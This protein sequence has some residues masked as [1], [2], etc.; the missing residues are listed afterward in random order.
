MTSRNLYSFEMSRGASG[1]WLG[2]VLLRLGPS[3]RYKVV[4]ETRHEDLEVV[5]EAC[6][7]YIAKAVGL[8]ERVLN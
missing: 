2:W 6:R 8:R 3:L 1:C 5:E 7:D 4:F